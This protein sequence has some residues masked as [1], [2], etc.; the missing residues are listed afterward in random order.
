MGEVEGIGVPLGYC[1]MSTATSIE[2]DKRARA[3]GA[4][5][6]CMKN[7]YG[8]DP[9]IVH[10]DKDAAEIKAMRMVWP[11]AKHQLCLWHLKK[12]VQSRLSK[13]KLSTVHYDP[14]TAHHEFPF[15]DV[16][17]RPVGLADPKEA[18]AE[19]IDMELDDPASAPQDP[20]TLHVRI[21][22][23]AAR[24]VLAANVLGDFS[25]AST[26]A[27][28]S[29]AS[30]NTALGPSAGIAHGG[31]PASSPDAAAS[32]SARARSGLGRA[33]T[34]VV[35]SAPASAMSGGDASLL[36]QFSELKRKLLSQNG[37]SSTAQPAESAG[38]H[39]GM[40]LLVCVSC[41]TMLTSICVGDHIFCPEDV[42]ADVVSMMERHL[43]AHPLIPGY[44][45]PTESGI[46]WWAVK[47]M[48]TFCYVHDLPELWA[49]LWGCW[50]APTRW[51]LWARST[52]AVIPR[53]RTTMICES[54]YVPSFLPNHD[55]V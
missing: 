27:S 52:C 19:D 4:F 21:P 31:T 53:L 41:T 54:Q 10:T 24:S 11:K 26:S 46:R 15:I 45:A 43:D 22:I 18:E 20:N 39:D 25:R 8:L 3:L 48:Y 29:S 51:K 30:S 6:D 17:F 1:M 7:K 35:S 13:A 49:Y 23:D 47:Q 40:L 9:Q 36:I 14:R 32:S 12:A 16:A 42:R 50:Y 55:T 34:D 33:P 2:K 38:R 37:G 44:S 5:L 28:A